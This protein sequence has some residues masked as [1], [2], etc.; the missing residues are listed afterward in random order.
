MAASA[1]EASLRGD[2]NSTMTGTRLDCASTSDSRFAS[3][4]S[5]V[6]SPPAEGSRDA[7]SCARC[8]RAERS[9]APD[10]AAAA[11]TAG[12][13]RVTPSSLSRRV[14]R[15]LR[16]RLAGRRSAGDRQLTGLISPYDK[17]HTAQWGN[18]S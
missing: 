9:T 13:G 11:A 16:R 7:G 6:H 10:M 15:A 3:V 4:T 8:L 18:A 1:A 5:T 14:R 12:R 2:P 17:D